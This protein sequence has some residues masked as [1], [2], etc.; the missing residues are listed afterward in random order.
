MPTHQVR[1]ENENGINY[2]EIGYRPTRYKN[3]VFYAMWLSCYKESALISNTF[4]L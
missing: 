3:S 4:N 1:L 2:Q